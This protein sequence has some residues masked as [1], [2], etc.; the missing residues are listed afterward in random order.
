MRGYA[1]T[2]SCLLSYAHDQAQ[3]HGFEFSALQQCEP[4]S[5]LLWPTARMENGGPVPGSVFRILN[6]TRN[7]CLAK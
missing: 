3:G 5:N 7:L 1:A 4:E 6:S 2:D